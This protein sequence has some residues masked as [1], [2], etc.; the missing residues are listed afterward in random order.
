MNNYSVVTYRDFIGIMYIIISFNYI[1][2][3]NKLVNNT[4]LDCSPFVHWNIGQLLHLW[5][6]KLKKKGE[7]LIWSCIHA[8]RQSEQTRSNMK[9]CVYVEYTIYVTAK[10]KVMCHFNVQNCY[11]RLIHG[12][13]LSFYMTKH[14]VIAKCNFIISME[15]QFLH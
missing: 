7:Y 15:V 9:S 4:G 13:T 3:C 6:R 12:Q 1:S 8:K 10:I 2:I 5:Y 14:N 11:M